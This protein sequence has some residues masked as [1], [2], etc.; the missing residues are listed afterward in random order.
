MD[1]KQ[2]ILSYVQKQTPSD[3][4]TLGFTVIK[5]S[6]QFQSAYKMHDIA[7]SYAVLQY[8]QNKFNIHPIGVD[9]RQHNVII[10]DELPNYFA[11]KDADV[12]CFDPKA[13]SSVKNFGWVNERASIS[14]RKLAGACNVKVYLNFL[15]VVGGKV[16]GEV[17][18][19]DIEK[20][21]IRKDRA[22]NGNPVWIYKWEKGLA[23]I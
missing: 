8:L 15:Q 11:E 22:W 7:C 5:T 4:S 14:Y 12:F 6:Q 9:L 18:H 2:C 10:Q 3:L 21:P 13:K 16:V 20:E 23:R 17:G 1:K 19:C